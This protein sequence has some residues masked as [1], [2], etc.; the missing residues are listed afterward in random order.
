MSNLQDVVEGSPTF[1]YQS[2]HELQQ[3]VDAARQAG[4]MDALCILEDML[5]VGA[6]CMS[7][8]VLAAENDGTI[9]AASQA[10][11]RAFFLDGPI[12]SWD[13]YRSIV[14]EYNYSKCVVILY[15]D[16]IED[17]SVRVWRSLRLGLSAVEA[18]DIVCVNLAALNLYRLYQEVGDGLPAVLV[19]PSVE[20]KT[21]YHFDTS[22]GIERFVAK[23][24]DDVAHKSAIVAAHARHQTEVFEKRKLIVAR[25]QRRNPTLKIPNPERE[26]KPIDPKLLVPQVGAE[27]RIV[28]YRP[29]PGA[30]QWSP[31]ENNAD[32]RAYFS[33]RAAENH[34][35]IEPPTKE[36][37]RSPASTLSSAQP[38]VPTPMSAIDRLTALTGL[39]QVKSEIVS[40]RKLLK[41]YGELKARNANPPTTSLHM[42]FTGNPGTGKTT[43]A[44]LLAEIYRDLGLLPKGHLVEV[45][46]S[47]LVA[48]YV[49]QTA[50]KVQEAI[51]EAMG[52]VLFVD[53]AYTLAGTGG[54]DFGREA[55]DTLMKAMEDRRGDFAVIVAGYSE[56]MKNFLGSNPGLASRFNREI[57]F[58][59][60][61]PDE[62]LE[63]FG[64]LV[65]D[66]GLRLDEG[67][68]RVAA[69]AFH[70]AYERRSS[71]FG[72][73]RY[74]RNTFEKMLERH[75][76]NVSNIKNPS[77]EEF[78]TIKS[79]DIVFLNG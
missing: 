57:F 17:E 54:N 4:N 37:I 24:S 21:Y 71:T 31:E 45:D 13:T 65:K 38:R 76:E 66:S 27:Q 78:L 5:R 8:L 70:A 11:I 44:R 68:R 32:L 43:V 75:A 47:G 48:G 42:I 50:I 49:G 9:S 33:R 51:K 14:E 77:D 6:L 28:R 12:A 35:P 39:R 55:I 18:T 46:R 59:D 23:I 22:F 60:Y 7:D 53:E 72:N 56:P 26:T 79:D 19:L 15:I 58:E 52:G 74:V 20:K 34:V 69:E 67:G 63:I 3:L 64:K 40:L 30:A 41:L 62:M 16:G 73:G 29:L 1:Q 10:A 2:T 61:V 25:L 36:E